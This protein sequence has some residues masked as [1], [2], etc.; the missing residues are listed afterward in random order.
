VQ[1]AEELVAPAVA[2]EQQMD[3]TQSEV[4]ANDVVTRK[5]LREL[6]PASGTHTS[7]LA[8][9]SLH[10]WVAAL[11]GFQVAIAAGVLLLGLLG[12]RRLS[13]LTEQVRATRQETQALRAELGT[14]TAE[15]RALKAESVEL[16]Q[17]VTR[18]IGE[19]EILLKILVLK[20]DVDLEVARN[21]ARHVRHYAVLYGRDADL[22]LSIMT[23]E[24]RFDPNAVSSVGAIGL[25]QVMPQ[26]QKVLGITGSL[27]DPETSIRYG[28]QILGFYMEMYKDVELALTAYN[29]GPG[30]V[31]MG[32]MKGKDPR[33]EYPGQVLRVYE[34]LKKMAMGHRPT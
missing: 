1:R 23:V 8:E 33:N 20:P 2:F 19:Q 4:A 12:Q 11:V 31:D 6:P 26:W 5:R 13:A 22:V 29:R 7:W 24:S 18:D 27:K 15:T 14:L 34:R 10:R 9:A 16:K 25:M 3:S 17:F 21:I 32:L 28:M 30:P